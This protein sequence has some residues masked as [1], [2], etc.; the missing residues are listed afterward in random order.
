[1][2]YRDFF[3]VQVIAFSVLSD[4]TPWFKQHRPYAKAWHSWA[5]FSTSVEEPHSCRDN[6]PLGLL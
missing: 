5:L 6:F 2:A 3:W 1:M 4:G